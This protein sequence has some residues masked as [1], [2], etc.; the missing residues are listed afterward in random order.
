MIK[1]YSFPT[2]EK[3]NELIALLSEENNPT[4]TEFTHAIV[5]LGFQDKWEYNQ[6]T[7]E[8]VLIHKGLT[9][10]VDIMWKAEPLE[11]F[12]PFEVNP[13]TPNHNFS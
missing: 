7:E 9:Y 12:N 5:M 2:E 1:R 11:E 8:S 13:K 4:V 6:E 10:D 3:A